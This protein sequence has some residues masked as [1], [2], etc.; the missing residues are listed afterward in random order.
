MI[1][2][3]SDTRASDLICMNCGNGCRELGIVKGYHVWRCGECDFALVNP[4]PSPAE[5]ADYYSDSYFDWHVEE[6]RIAGDRIASA[7]RLEILNRLTKDK[8][9]LD[10]GSGNGVFIQEAKQRGWDGGLVELNPIM[11]AKTST[12][13]SMLSWENLENVDRKFS[14]VSMWEYIEHITTPESQVQKVRSILNDDGV[15]ALSTPNSRAIWSEREFLS[16]E[17]VKPP[18]HLLFWNDLNLKSFI[19]RNGFQ[20]IGARHIGFSPL[21]YAWRHF[22][23]RSDPKTKLWPFA[24]LLGLVAAPIWETRFKETITWRS[25]IYEGLEL[26]FRAS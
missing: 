4:F 21:L 23:R 20:L 10:V 9:L 26:Y 11:R 7:N 25:R 19:E 16:W 22:G 12:D 17:Q 13:N 8:C 6:G 5:V 24:S 18:E 3:A 14:V 1:T 15:F 2:T